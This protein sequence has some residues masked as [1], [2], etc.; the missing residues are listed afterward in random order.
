MSHRFHTGFGLQASWPRCG[1][2]SMAVQFIFEVF[3][4]K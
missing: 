1:S 3:G 4:Q 2:S